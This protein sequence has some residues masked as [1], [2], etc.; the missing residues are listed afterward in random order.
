M[1]STEMEFPDANSP[2]LHLTHP[3]PAENVET[4]TLNSVNWGTSLSTPDYLE[5][6]AYLTT[7]PLA[8]DGGITHWIL[9]DRNLPPNL[10]PILASCE[11]LRKPVLVSHNGEV[12]EEITHGIGSVFSQPKFRGKGYASR[13]L[14]ELA[15]LLQDWQVDEKSGNCSF[16]VL[17]SDIGKKYYNK[18]GWAPF[19]SAHIELK[20]AAKPHST[21]VTKLS[22][23]DIPE[24]CQLDVQYIRKALA[25]T[26]DGKTHV[27]VIPNHDQMQWHH[28]RED[29]VCNKLFKRHPHIKGAMAGK[30]G[31]RIWTIWTRAYYG[32]LNEP[33]SGNTLHLLRLVIE[34]DSATAEN[35][36]SL[37][38]ILELA[39]AE[40]KEWQLDAVD[41]WNPS[42][43]VRKLVEMTGLESEWVDRQEESIA[44][45]MWYGEGASADV[46]WLA[47]EKY[48]WC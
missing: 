31:S 2:S 47:N 11:T 24:L 46:S 35:V 5:R 38:A 36:E 3:T 32:P 9:V 41:L 48:G 14:K 42:T 6:E 33:K 15:P 34:D 18:F 30:P 4:W 1:G 43:G 20:P 27:A 10:R 25:N 44:S 16:S 17:Y 45:L 23:P 37:K 26:K 19:P 8:K 40:A 13:M 12:K 21:N 22:C 7:I 28:K 29:F 39:Q